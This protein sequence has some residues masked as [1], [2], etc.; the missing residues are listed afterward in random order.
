MQVAIK[1]YRYVQEFMRRTK[2]PAVTFQVN[3]VSVRRPGICRW[4]VA[5]IDCSYKWSGVAASTAAPFFN[6]SR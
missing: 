6:P 1:A 4:W 3:P 5:A 2:S